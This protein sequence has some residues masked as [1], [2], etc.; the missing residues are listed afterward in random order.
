[1]RFN[2]ALSRQNLAKQDK[3]WKCWQE[4]CEYMSVVIAWLQFLEPKNIL[5]AGCNNAPVCLDSDT[6][7][8]NSDAKV[9]HDLTKTPWPFEHK[10]YDVFVALQVWEH[11]KGRQQRAFGEAERISHH[12]IISIPYKWDRPDN[13]HDMIDENILFNWTGRVPD[14]TFITNETTQYKR[15]ICY[16]RN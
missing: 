4:R 7:G 3:Y 10:Q 16:W 6:V 8:L 15:M 2:N 1:M 14:K 9:I 12:I 13:C 5:E 11:L